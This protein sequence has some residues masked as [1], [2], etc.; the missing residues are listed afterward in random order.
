VVTVTKWCCTACSAASGAAD[1]RTSDAHGSQL[2]LLPPAV[3]EAGGAPEAH[4]APLLGARRASSALCARS[5]SSVA[6]RAASV[7]RSAC[8]DAT[9]ER[10]SSCSESVHSEKRAAA[11]ARRVRA[12]QKQYASQRDPTADGTQNGGTR[13][14]VKACA[15]LRRQLRRE[16]HHGAAG[17]RGAGVRE[18][19]TRGPGCAS[20]RVAAQRLRKRERG[21]RK[22][23]QTLLCAWAGSGRALTR[24][25]AAASAAPRA[26]RAGC[27]PPPWRRPARRRR[28][29]GAGAARQR[30][31]R[32]LRALRR[33]ALQPA[34]LPRLRARRTARPPPRAPPPPPQRRRQR[35]AR[36]APRRSETPK[37]RA[38]RCAHGV[39]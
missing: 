26:P 22:R 35:P 12:R 17:G 7:S 18:A 27:A 11:S 4:D 34:P 6:T 31:S 24:R 37:R 38:A 19:D 25:T 1:A 5:R 2:P 28:R 14:L 20:A 3:G 21:R 29:L 13:L 10:S 16:L 23:P 8:S 39:W 33:V 30:A 36:A 32:A 15:A 9:A